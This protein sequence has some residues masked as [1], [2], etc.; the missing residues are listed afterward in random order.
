MQQ[1]PPEPEAREKSTVVLIG[2]PNV[3]KSVVFA[4]MTGRYAAV[5]NYPGTTVEVSKGRA[6]FNP[7]LIV[8]DTPGANSLHPQSLDEKVTRDILLTVPVD[9]VVQVAD[10]KNLRRGLTITTQL[11]EMGFPVVLSL[12][13]MDE[14][15]RRG[16]RISSEAL[17]EAIKIPVVE[18]VATEKKGLRNLV[19]AVS[20]SSSVPAITVDYPPAVEEAIGRIAAF[21]PE[22]P[23]RKR[24]LAIMFLADPV[25][26]TE[27]LVPLVGREQAGKAARIA[28][29]VQEKFSNPLSY[30]I[31]V[32]RSRTV[33]RL[34]DTVFLKD[35]RALG[36]AARARMRRKQAFVALAI[37]ALS[38]ILYATFG[39]ERLAGWGL[40]PTLLHIV[41]LLF[42]FTLLPYRVMELVTTHS[43]LGALFLLEIL[44]LMYKLVGV[45]GAGTLVDLMENGLFKTYLIPFVRS[46]LERA[47]PVPFLNDLLT[48][49][50]GLI[51]MGLTYSLAIVMPIV[52]IFFFMFGVLEDSGY[53]PR[54][55]VVAD[56]AMRRIGLN[57][58]AVLPMV[59]GLG[60]VTMATLTT[61]IL[62]T[63]KERIIATLLLALGIPCSAQLGVI[64]AIVSQCS[65]LVMAT[66]VG[67]VLMQLF[68]VG[69]LSA[70]FV[71]G[72][73]SDFIMELPPL[74]PPLMMHIITK[75]G[76]RMRW[77]LIEAVPFFLAGTLLLFIIDRAGIINLLE[78]SA[79]PVIGRLLGLPVESTFAF[80]IGFFRRDYGA[81]GLFDL[82]RNGML[83]HNQ[84]AVSMIVITLFVPCIANFFVM[85]KERGLGTAVAMV[86]FILPYAIL[87]GTLV[88]VFLSLTGISL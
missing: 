1:H 29:R 72:K 22:L 36:E 34:L 59:L 24:A 69:A 77:F 78:K 4:Y 43:V 10:A 75:T 15:T 37:T 62:D 41:T 88:N 70:R 74:R 79:R 53:L 19:S 5:S 35:V 60:C 7:K 48:G 71:K 47:M 21:M 12:N 51:S 83:D 9:T 28:E 32:S 76:H 73:S 85:I 58:K 49:E 6:L 87:V 66:V 50:Y 40:H 81:A 54:L 86:A 56:R 3:G 64:F 30:I 80:I 20:D 82:F 55:S 14:A 11:A 26:A 44:Y 61:R 17:A 18:T 68:I 16:I 13:M 25:E 33:D 46:G 42:L 23:I 8:I 39:M 27:F 84:V 57:G 52:A 67:V 38:L 45:F 63:K 65:P 31:G 2:N